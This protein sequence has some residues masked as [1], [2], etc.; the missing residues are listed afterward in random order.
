VANA[1]TNSG[2]PVGPVL[3]VSS[4]YGTPRHRCQYPREALGKLSIRADLANAED[5]DLLSRCAGYS[6]LVLNRV[7]YTR[8][9][10]GAVARAREAGAKVLF[11]VDDLI[12]E[13]ELLAQLPFVAAYPAERRSRLLL[14]AA[15]IRDGML[16]CG[17]GTS[18]TATLGRE[19]RP[20]SP[21][22]VV[23]NCV[24]D[25][26]VNLSLQAAE[27]RRPNGSVS[28][29]FLCGHHGHESNFA[30]IRE[31]LRVLLARRH[32]LRLRIVGF[33]NELV[34]GLERYADRIDTTPYVDWHVLPA[35][36]A[37]MDVCLAPLT[38]DRFNACKSDLRYLESALCGVPIVASPVGQFP[39]TIVDGHNGLLA[40][41]EDDWIAKLE[42][43]LGDPDRRAALGGAARRDVLAHRR[44]DTMGRALVRALVES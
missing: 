10:A 34:R 30:L 22:L 16:A 33:F 4:A 11:D 1:Q 37:R 9:I 32:G 2:P 8:E 3:F 41:T 26:V 23:E 17:R 21:V 14:A 12:F 15:Q 28:V 18:S 20:L 13:P 25:A 36:L 7:P 44:T 40:A 43:L 35:E 6:H 27:K 31:P 29:G 42:T 24:S 39:E 5:S 38:A 19:V